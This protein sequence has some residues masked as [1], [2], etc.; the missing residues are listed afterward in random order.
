MIHTTVF[1]QEYIS[2]KVIEKSGEPIPGATIQLGNSR[3]SQMSDLNGDF[4]ILKPTEKGVTMTISFI[5][6]E[7]VKIENIDTIFHPLTIIMKEIPGG[8]IDYVY[9]SRD[10]FVKNPAYSNI[11]FIFSSQ[12][13]GLKTSFNNFESILGKENVDNLKL[14][15]NVGF[16]YAFS[17]RGLY[18]ALNHGHVTGGEGVELDSVDARK[19]KYKTFLLGTHFGYN[20]V[21]SKRFLITPKVGVKWYRYRILNYDSDWSIPMEQYITNMDLDIRFNHLIGFAG[22]SCN[23]KVAYIDETTSLLLGFYGGYAF[24]LND[25]PWIYSGN[26]RLIT[27]KKIDFSNFNFG[28]TVSVIFN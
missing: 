18:F 11:G 25:K 3:N 19:G 26:N 17:Y 4:R 2:G 5:G 20:I 22:V 28:M 9:V 12:I 6:F 8:H 24:K 23:Y 14:H 27:D 16:E 7:T 21:N 13:D 15:L 1:S 10:Y